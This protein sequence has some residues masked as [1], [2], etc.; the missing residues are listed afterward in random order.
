LAWIEA[1]LKAFASESIIKS[2]QLCDIDWGGKL[3]MVFKLTVSSCPAVAD[4]PFN[5]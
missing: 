2:S 4:M 5:T 1:S 3:L